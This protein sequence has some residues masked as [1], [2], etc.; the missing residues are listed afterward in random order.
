[1]REKMAKVTIVNEGVSFE[2]PENSRLLDYIKENS[3]M[4]FGC[5]NA[6]CATCICTVLRGEE[7]LLPRNHNEDVT[8]QNNG[9]SQRQ[10]LGCQIWIKKGEIEIEY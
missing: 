8:L 1:L 9:A 6:Q 2:V 4:L 3:G 10:R 5:E 7:N